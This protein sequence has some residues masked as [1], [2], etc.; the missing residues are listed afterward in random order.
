MRAADPHRWT[1]SCP[2]TEAPCC[3]A[4]QDNGAAPISESAL[5]CHAMSSQQ[6]TSLPSLPC[7]PCP[8]DASC[9]AYGVTLSDDEAAAIEANHG[10]GLVYKT[11][12]GEW[13][14]RIRNKRCSL[15]PRRGLHDSRPVILSRRVPRLSLDRC[16]NGWALR[17]RRHH[18]RR[19]R[20]TSGVGRDSTRYSAAERRLGEAPELNERPGRTISAGR[21]NDA[22]TESAE[23]HRPTTPHSHNRQSQTP[24]RPAVRCAS[25]QTALRRKA[26]RC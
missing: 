8:Y 9:C 12:W 24:E 18:L 20:S 26:R 25:H 10:P 22:P 14:T 4:F 15:Y 11:R 17:V 16:R 19:A 6:Q 23:M 3:A 5:L 2:R 21:A 7:Y 1:K 13:R